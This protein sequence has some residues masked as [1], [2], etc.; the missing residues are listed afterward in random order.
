MKKL[1]MKNRIIWVVLASLLLGS[2]VFGYIRVIRPTLLGETFG[3]TQETLPTF[4]KS[5]NSILPRDTDADFGLGSSATSSAPFSVNI[6][7][8]DVT[9]YGSGSF[10]GFGL[11]D[12]DADGQT[13]S[14]DATTGQFGCGD[15]DNSGGGG[16]GLSYIQVR[17]SDGAFANI[18]SLSFE[19]GHFN[20]TNA[21]PLSTVKL[22]WTNGPASRSADQTISGDWDFTNTGS[23]SAAGEWNFD[24]NTLV[25]DSGTDTVSVRT[26]VPLVRGLTVVGTAGSAAPGGLPNDALTPAV[27]YNSNA[28]SSDARIA[29]GSGATGKASVFFGDTGDFTMGRVTY[30]NNL[31]AMQLWTADA[32]QLTINSSGNVGIGTSNIDTKFEVLGT[33]S[34]SGASS[35][36]TNIVVGTPT[37]IDVDTATC[38]AFQVVG[39]DANTAQTQIRYSTSAAGRPRYIFA[40]SK[41]ATLGTNTALETDDIIGSIEFAPANGTDFED[42]AAEIRGVSS[43]TQVAGSVSGYLLFMTSNDATSPTERMRIGPTGDITFSGVG[44]SSFAGSL[45]VAK[46]LTANSWQ[47][48]GLQ[49]CDPTTGKLVYAAGQFS[50]GTDQAGSGSSLWTQSG[51]LTYLT[52]T[53]DDVAIGGSASTSAPF[54]VNLTALTDAVI[55]LGGSTTASLSLGIDDSDSNAFVIST[56]DTLGTSNLFR[57]FS[58][59]ATLSTNFETTGYASVSRLFMAAGSATAPSIALQSNKQTGFYDLGQFFGITFSGTN[60]YNLSFTTFESANTGGFSMT[61]AAGTVNTPAYGFKNDENTGIYRIDTDTLGFSTGGVKRASVSASAWEFNV[62]ASMSST[63]W[64]GGNTTILGTLN[65][66]GLSSFVNASVSGDFEVGT[67][68][69]LVGSSGALTHTG[70]VS[71]QTLA[72]VSPKFSLFYKGADEITALA[73]GTSGQVLQSGGTTGAP[74]WVSPSGGAT[75]G[76]DIVYNTTSPATA[77]DLDLSSVVGAAQKMVY[78]RVE[79]NSNDSCMFAENG[80]SPQANGDTGGAASVNR[81]NSNQTLYVLVATDSSGIVEW[82]CTSGSTATVRVISFW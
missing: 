11:S 74:S 73:P 1:K 70:S 77:Q 3:D 82:D 28:A 63:L 59:G 37:C 54:V 52:D 46:G 80:R 57:L 8:D 53:N 10:T 31:D 42:S 13:V 43:K 60:R 6:R 49:T 48:G 24:S 19:A 40:H 76:T 12:C 9:L 7:G 27:F 81:Q 55:K 65:V 14:W 68:F 62:P 56:G 75:Y 23:H 61:G 45:S 36:G 5:G 69:K 38:S 41:S 66:T 30:D 67:K 50:C 20:I 34:I 58:G 18:S 78:L 47:G 16:G 15:D 51:N 4:R 79:L 25:I 72:T 2:G 26:S 64:V 29:I 44:S 32:Q 39:T 35:F 22:D 21:A 33:A 71:F 17:E